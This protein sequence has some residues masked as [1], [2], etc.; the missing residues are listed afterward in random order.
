MG[1]DIYMPDPFLE[2]LQ[3]MLD[4]ITQDKEELCLCPLDN[5]MAYG[6]TCGAII[7][8]RKL[9]DRKKV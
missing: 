1:D 6:C 7:I 4:R 2:E 9:R 5:L 3:D 8:E